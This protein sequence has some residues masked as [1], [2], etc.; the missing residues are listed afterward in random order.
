MEAFDRER[1]GGP[2]Q[3]TEIGE[4]DR[5]PDAGFVRGPLPDLGR[6]RIS[7]GQI[8]EQSREQKAREADEHASGPVNLAIYAPSE[9]KEMSPQLMCSSRH[10]LDSM[11]SVIQ[12][13]QS[14][15]SSLIE[16]LARVW[17]STRFTMTAQ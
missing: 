11:C 5:G 17:P 14:R 8:G 16:V 4:P 1:G 3:K 6:K 10:R 15:N 12:P 2:D 9:T 13:C 7:R